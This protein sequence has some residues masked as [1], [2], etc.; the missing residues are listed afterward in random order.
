[1]TFHL[2]RIPV[3]AVL[4]TLA[5]CSPAAPAASPTN[6]AEGPSIAAPSPSL[7]S[8]AK[9]ATRAE[10]PTPSWTATPKPT[11][12][13]PLPPEGPYFAFINQN[14][15]ASVL[16]LL[17]MHGIGR[18]EIT[19]PEDADTG[20]CSSCVISP[21]GEWLAYWITSTVVPD[22]ATQLPESPNRLTLNLLHISDG[23]T[24]ILTELLSPDYAQIFRTNAEAVKNFPGFDGRDVLDIA[25]ELYSSFWYGIQSA[26]WSPDGRYLAFAGEM[27]GPS[28]D[29]YVYDMSRQSIRRLSSGPKNILP[30]GY[31][32][33]Y[34]SPDGK[35]IAYSSGY[36]I[37][38]G[39]TVSFYAARPDD[40]LFR[41]FPDEVTNWQGWVSS[42]QFLVGLGENGIGAYGLR[43]ADLVSGKMSTIWRCPYYYY[44]YDP[45]GRTLLFVMHGSVALQ[46]EDVSGL[47]LH[48][49]LS[50]D[51][52][53]SLGEENYPFIQ[54]FFL[55]QGDRRFLAYVINTGTYAISRT[56][57]ATLILD[58]HL[59]PNIS[60]DRQWVAFA[61]NHTPATS[62]DGKS[63]RIM[64][65]SGNISEPLIEMEIDEVFW[66]PDSE[67]FL[68]SAGSDVYYVSI[69]DRQVVLWEDAKLP[70]KI[71]QVHWQPDSQ[72]LFFL[73]VSDLYFLSLPKKSITKIHDSLS[74]ISFDPAWVAGPE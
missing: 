46:C 58:E 56:R 65:P 57:T 40:S 33:I 52:P 30:A 49:N 60:P 5:A 26:A 36:W 34:W 24:S 44:S 43:I 61:G 20:N 12:I 11:D 15:D 10:Q 25:L 64:D 62:A 41:D 73:S 18:K 21:D 14:G 54:P 68:F 71:E 22:D 17:G 72:G 28:S 2:R 32:S 1:M 63:L 69:S 16:T 59:F 4:F 3:F 51:M 55:G 70:S 50:G 66:R 38:E 9:T 42:S 53:I 6:T 23:S 67:G 74:W 39:M 19:L 27:D 48:E 35:W 7:A 29:L 8:P 13:L 31:Q 37:G 47:F 45:E